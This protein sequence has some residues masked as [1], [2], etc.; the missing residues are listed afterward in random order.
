[1][2]NESSLSVTSTAY[3][4]LHYRLADLNGVDI[5][6]TFHGNPATLQLG[7]G[8]L[9][10]FLEA[11]LLGLPEGVHRT[12]ILS[13]E[14]AYGESNPDLI[15]M[16]SRLTLELNNAANR[17]LSVGDTVEFMAPGGGRFTGILKEAGGDGAWFDFN[18]P[19]AGKSLIFEA[20]IIAI[21]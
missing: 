9:A 5:V 8:Q 2:S 10:P 17:Q 20:K 19:L 11:Q 14:N 12:S 21:L 18:H 1:M 16:V 3:L 15:R 6:T 4:T 7:A 13:P